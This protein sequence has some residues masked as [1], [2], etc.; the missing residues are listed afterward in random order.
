MESWLLCPFSTLFYLVQNSIN[1]HQ[2]RGKSYYNGCIDT[3]MKISCQK[4]KLESNHSWITSFFF[5]LKHLL[6]SYK[7]NREKKNFQCS[8]NIYVSIQEVLSLYV[9]GRTIDIVLDI[10]DGVCQTSLFLFMKDI[11]FLMLFLDFDWFRKI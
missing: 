7:F 1:C 11:I 5:Y 9:F 2:W 4:K 3:N 6:K 10:G 8:Y